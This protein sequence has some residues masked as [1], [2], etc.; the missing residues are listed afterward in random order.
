MNEQRFLSLDVFR[1]L[2]VCL[3]IVV[4]SPGSWSD[5]YPMLEHASWHGF[6]LTDLVFPSFLFAVGNSLAFTR[7]NDTGDQVFW[8]KTLKRFVL[9]FL[10]GLLLHWFPFVN[11][12]TGELISLDTL[13]IMGVLQRIALCYLIAAVI[14][15]YA[16]KQM[17][18]IISVLILLLYWAILYF[19][20]QTPDPYSIT[21]FS[22]NTLDFLLIGKNHLYTGE[23]VPFDPEG[24]LSTLPASI[25]VLGGYL[26]GEFIRRKGA[27]ASTLKKLLLT[28]TGLILIGLVW[29]GLFPINKKIWTSSF[30]S[31]TLGFDLVILAI[32]IGTIEIQK[33]SKWS[34]FFVVFGRNP[35]AIYILSNMLIVFLYS[36]RFESDSVYAITYHTFAEWLPAKAASLLFAVLFMLLCWMIGLWMDRKK[37]YLR[38]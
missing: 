18:I 25:N 17:I 27:T 4:N 26:A 5:I 7:K 29:H 24:L 3:M 16:T 37:I 14:I 9:I 6:T 28:A 8:K 21:G 12:G 34:Y 10:I 1:G 22:G 23:G 35:L 33:F 15:H 38:V 13:R 36:I 30:V 2:T 31:L 19:F 11:I 32:L 20:A